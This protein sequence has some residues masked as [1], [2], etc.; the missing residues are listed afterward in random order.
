MDKTKKIRP[1]GPLPTHWVRPVDLKPGDLV[2]NHGMGHATVLSSDLVE[3][4]SQ[5]PNGR[6]K[7][8]EWWVTYVYPGPEGKI[9][10]QTER[11]PA[12]KMAL[13]CV[14]VIRDTTLPSE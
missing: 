7:K 13:N 6:V 1:I 10:K 14:G 12:R 3:P 2:T 11:F 5:S 8:H 4:G 9:L